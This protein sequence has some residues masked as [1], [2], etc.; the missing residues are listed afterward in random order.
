MAS[1][2]A[3]T[4][5]ATIRTDE[6]FKLYLPSVHEN[7]SAKKIFAVMANLGIGRLGRTDGGDAIEITDHVSR[8]DGRSY[9]TAVVYFQHPFTRGEDGERNKAALGHLREDPDNFLEVEHM[10]EKTKDDGTV[11]QA[12]VW[13][14]RLDRPRVTHDTVAT[15]R[16][17]LVFGRQQ[18]K[19]KVR[20]LDAGE[21]WGDDVVATPGATEDEALEAVRAAAA[22]DTADTATAEGDEDTELTDEQYVEQVMAGKSA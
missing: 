8:A 20:M 13:R 16:P 15:D 3:Q 6:S 2:S 17:T 10:P 14:A 5:S 18:R 21:D 7:T 11:L 1:A 12:R 19:P 22:A 9:K 4:S